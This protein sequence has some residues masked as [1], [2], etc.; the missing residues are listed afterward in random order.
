VSFGAKVQLREKKQLNHDNG[1]RFLAFG[2]AASSAE[3]IHVTSP[4]SM[5]PDGVAMRWRKRHH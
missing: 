4:E 3:I 2:V 1:P 5:A